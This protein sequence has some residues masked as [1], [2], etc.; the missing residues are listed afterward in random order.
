MVVAAP[1]AAV[2][3]E[4]GVEAAALEL[5]EEPPQATRET[6]MAEARASARIFF[7]LNFSF[8]L[9]CRFFL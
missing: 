9:G 2:L 1:E 8:I 3:P 6:A 4:A 7:I 5:L